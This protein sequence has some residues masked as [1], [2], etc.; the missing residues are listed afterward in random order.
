MKI[1]FFSILAVII[2]GIG[3]FAFMDKQNRGPRE[4][5][6]NPNTE[7]VAEVDSVTETTVP[8]KKMSFGQFVQQGGSYK[9]TVDQY[10]NGDYS[11]ATEGEVY[12]DGGMIRGDYVVE[13]QGMSL[14][15]S[16]IVRDGFVY[17]WTSLAPNG[18]KVPVDMN[19]SSQ[20]DTAMSGAYAWNADQIGDYDCVDWNAD[21]SL[22]VVP[23]DITFQE[24]T[25]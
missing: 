4:T 15:T 10:I 19:A 2:I 1:F 3:V 21:A 12:I 7:E 16:V 5:L 25:A 6:E 20:A 13:A 18:V 11:N 23:A 24:I 17:S 14:D 9:C 22:F 8:E